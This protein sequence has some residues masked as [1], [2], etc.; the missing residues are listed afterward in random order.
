MNSTVCHML[1]HFRQLSLQDGWSPVHVAAR[2]GHLHI[3]RELVEKLNADVLATKP[4]CLWFILHVK[5]PN[6]YKAT[7]TFCLYRTS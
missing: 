6:M 4:V 3:V 7:S 2:S 1:Y 5:S